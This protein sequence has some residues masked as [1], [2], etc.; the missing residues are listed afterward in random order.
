MLFMGSHAGRAITSDT[1]DAKPG[2]I[3]VAHRMKPIFD[4]LL[5]LPRF[6]MRRN[7]LF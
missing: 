6:P 7:N 4:S 5:D 2:P 1:L 3:S